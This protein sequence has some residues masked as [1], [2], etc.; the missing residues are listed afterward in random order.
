M[1]VKKKLYR[2]KDGSKIAGVC[3]G[4]SGYFEVDPMRWTTKGL[5]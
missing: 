5:L 4:I 3:A 1:A 2:N